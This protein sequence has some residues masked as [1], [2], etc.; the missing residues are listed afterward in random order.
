MG[1]PYYML[2]CYKSG[3]ARLFDI[4]NLFFWERIGR[5]MLVLGSKDRWFETLRKHCVASLIKTF[6]PMLSIGLTQEDGKTS[7][8]D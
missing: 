4:T 1:H 8:H 7:R 2:K 6:Y 3:S 5:L